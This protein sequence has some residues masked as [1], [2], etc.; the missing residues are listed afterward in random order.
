[1]LIERGAIERQGDRW[2]A[3]AAIE[4]V[5]IPETLHGLLL[6]RID[7]LPETAQAQPAGRV[8]DRTP[9]PG[10]RPRARPRADEPDRSRGDGR[11]ADAARHP[12]GEGPHPRSP[13]PG[14]SSSTSSA[15]GSSRTPPTNRCSSRSAAQL[16]RLVGEAL[17]E[18]Y[19]DRR[20]ELAGVLAM[21][22]EQAGDTEQGRRVPRGGGP[23]RARAERDPGGLR[24]LRSGAR[25]CSRRPTAGCRR[26]TTRAGARRDRA[27]PARGRLDL[28]ADRRGH[29]RARG[30]SLPSA[31]RLG[32]LELIAQIHLSSRW[33]GC[34]TRRA[35]HG[36]GRASARSTASPRSARRSTIPR[37]ARCRS[38]SSALDQVF[39]GPSARASW[40]SRRPSRCWRSAATSSARPSRGVRSPSATPTSA[41]STRPRRR[42]RNATEL[43]RRAA[44]SSPSST[45]RSP[46][47]WSTPC[48]AISTRRSRWP[49][50]AC[51][52]RGDRRDGVRGRELMDPR[53][54]RTIGRVKL[55]RGQPS[56]AARARTI[57][58]V[59]DRKVWRPTLQAWLG[60]TSAALGEV[61]ASEGDWEEA[62]A[63]ARSIGNRYGEA[64]ILC[65][66]CRGG[67]E[68]RRHGGGARRLRGQ[69]GHRR[70]VRRAARPGPD[71]ARLGRDA[72]RESRA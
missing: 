59:V 62:L 38:P 5:E 3:T 24:G 27:R 6:A 43:G 61:A 18:L 15:T 1:M 46:Q 63:T 68:A 70:G 67:G 14:R 12:R 65:E 57:A 72:A 22:F 48:A 16:H 10:P 56:A 35:A 4:S 2:V 58:L 20:G 33:H 45:R 17:E 42:P 53:R 55:R 51:P 21:H 60:S 23:L 40:P 52:R 49:R 29:R 64:G 54:R 28:P 32:D 66:A 37:C 19:P 26:S 13:R 34:Q 47:S 36:P 41:S 39:T 44:T 8:G 30:A 69:R 71:P 50:P 25:S 7:Q 31:E 11:V 9:V